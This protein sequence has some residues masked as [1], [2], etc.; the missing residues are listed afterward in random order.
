[1]SE[2]DFSKVKEWEIGGKNVV[3]AERNGV[4]V[5]TK[6]TVTPEEDP[7]KGSWLL[8]TKVSSSLFNSSKL[9]YVNFK[10]NDISYSSLSISSKKLYYGNTQVAV[11]NDNNKNLS[12]TNENY[13]TIEILDEITAVEN[14]Y[15]LLEILENNAERVTN[16][17]HGGGSN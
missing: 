10:S 8:S 6:P 14:G 12:W 1:M 3:K 4:V 7:L 17:E 9:Y 16:S 11:Y 2:I 5:W 15:E 13:R